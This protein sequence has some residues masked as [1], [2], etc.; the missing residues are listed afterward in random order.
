MVTNRLKSW[1]SC[2][3]DLDEQDLIVCRRPLVREKGRRR[4]LDSERAQCLPFQP[5]QL[6]NLF[7]GNVKS[8]IVRA[9]CYLAD[10]R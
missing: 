5:D 10:E 3:S 7:A 1:C 2:V 8:L 6:F 4:F 9:P